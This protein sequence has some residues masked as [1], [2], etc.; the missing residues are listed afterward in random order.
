MSGYILV[1]HFIYNFPS[2][3]HS[4]GGETVKGVKTGA[5]DQTEVDEE[6]SQKPN[7]TMR[8]YFNRMNRKHVGRMKVYADTDTDTEDKDSG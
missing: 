7:E 6:L 4:E 3:I 8:Q 2:P 5:R 1:I